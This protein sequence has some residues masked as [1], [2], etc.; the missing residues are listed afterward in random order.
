MKRELENAHA[1]NIRTFI[2]LDGQ[3]FECK[4]LAFVPALVSVCVCPSVHVC[5]HG[6]MCM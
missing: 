2:R 3:M 5:I 1:A 4:K 6:L